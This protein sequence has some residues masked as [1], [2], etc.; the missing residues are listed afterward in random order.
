MFRGVIIEESLEDKNVLKRFPVLEKE[1]EQVTPNFG[2]PWLTEW[3][4]HTIEV[5]DDQIA[6]YAKEVQ[7]ALDGARHNWYADFKTDTTHYIIFKGR[8]FV[9][10]RTKKEEYQEAQDYGISLGIPPHQ[11]NFTANTVTI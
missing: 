2:T 8:V 5:P 10:D 3:N 9:I 6:E 11:V 7:S 1:T 4:L